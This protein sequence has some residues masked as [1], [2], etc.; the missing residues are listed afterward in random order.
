V[1]STKKFL[2]KFNVIAAAAMTSNITSAI[3]NIESLDDVGIQFTWSGAPVGTFRIEVSAD[4]AQ[5]IQGNVTVP[6]AW[7]P[8]TFTYYD[9]ASNVTTSELPTSVGSPIFADL[10]LLSAPWIRSVYTFISGSGTLT[11]TITAKMV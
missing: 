8:I 4:H 11:T 5:D 3:T 1:G 9:G 10:S 7:A 6:G 2:P